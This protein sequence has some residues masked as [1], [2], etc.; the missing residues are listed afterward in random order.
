MLNQ[1]RK[2]KLSTNKN[3]N[4]IVFERPEFLYESEYE[5]LTEREEKD[6][7]FLIERIETDINNRESKIVAYL[8]PNGSGKS[9]VLKQSIETV[10]EKYDTRPTIYEIWQYQNE[11][12]MWENFLIAVLSKNNSP[13]SKNRV[14]RKIKN[15]SIRKIYVA[16]QIIA[17]ILIAFL[18]FCFVS[19]NV[20]DEKQYVNIGSLI[21]SIFG[22][23]VFGLILTQFLTTG[24]VG[25]VYQY[26]NE[27]LKY[28]K[29][30]K[31][32]PIVVI[33]EDVDRTQRGENVVE[34]L[35]SFINTNRALIKTPIIA[36]CPMSRS[37]FYGSRLDDK[38][39]R[40]EKI[41]L[42]NKI[43]DYAINS[44]LTGSVLE[45][46]IDK[47]LKLSS[48]KSKNLK[49][50]M[51]SIMQA[52][53]KD[54]SLLN[55]RA[56]KFILRDVNQFIERYP[57]LDESI[58]FLFASEK[59]I[60]TKINRI[61]GGDG[62]IRM[63]LLNESGTATNSFNTSPEFSRMFGESFGITKL[64][65]DN[66]I[67]G[68]NFSIPLHFNYTGDDNPHTVSIADDKRSISISLSGHYKEL[69]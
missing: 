13:K 31:K 54:E 57:S 26:E 21:F 64:M 35:H 44:S 42:S 41:E 69:L 14:A 62:A 30:E 18:S 49:P 33:I 28:L 20:G 36:I 9:T 67:P 8:G 59:Y 10:L 7:N 12:K 11:D 37:S 45:S 34:S 43:Y 50:T 32:K 6:H 53:K 61:S 55:I 15:G 3:R 19:V 29:K 27:L 63:A 46:D 2:N 1:K 68:S 56:L 5:E 23:G 47:L 52:S 39:K 4:K 25:Y 22:F 24:G 51:L 40:L 48:C 66:K 60:S 65:E 38:A 17:C 58:A 16:L